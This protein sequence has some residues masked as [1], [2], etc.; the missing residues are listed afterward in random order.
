MFLNVD[1]HMY[2]SQEFTHKMELLS[3]SWYFSV[4]FHQRRSL[5]ILEFGL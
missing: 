4:C 3:L 5:L 1:L 2:T